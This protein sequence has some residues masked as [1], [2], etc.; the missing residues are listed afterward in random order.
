MMISSCERDRFYI[1]SYSS[2][3]DPFTETRILERPYELNL[4]HLAFLV[5]MPMSL[6]LG[7]QILMPIMLLLVKSIQCRDTRVPQQYLGNVESFF[8][9][10]NTVLTTRSV[11]LEAYIDKYSS[12]V[13]YL[14]DTAPTSTPSSDAA[15]AEQTSKAI[16]LQVCEWLPLRAHLTLL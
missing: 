4:S 12:L 2:V 5:T 15:P 8:F 16:S 11:T 7:Q 3:S 10:S 14:A 13:P 1:H 6:L 9:R